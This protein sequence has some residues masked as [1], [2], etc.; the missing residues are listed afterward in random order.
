MTQFFWNKKNIRLKPE[1][2]LVIGFASLILVGSLLLSLPAATQSGESTSYLD[3]LFTSTSAVCVTGLVVYDTGTH[4]SMF[5]QTLIALLIQ[6]GGLGFMTFGILFAV[7]LGRKIGLRSRLVLQESLREFSLHGVV[8]LAARILLVTLVVELLATSLLATKFVPTL[9]LWRG[10]WF[11]FFHSVSAFNNAGFDIFGSINGQF[12][13]LT[14]YVTE[15]LVVL[16]LA[17]LFIM[18]GIG[19]TVFMDAVQKRKFKDLALHSKLVLWTTGIL[20]MVATLVIFSLERTNLQTIGNMSFGTGLMN[21]F[22]QAVTPRTAGFNTL[23]IAS[24]TMASQMFIILLMYVGA[25]PGS[26]GGGIKTSTFAVM[27]AG[28]TTLMGQKRDVVLFNRK[29]PSHQINKVFFILVLSLGVILLNTFLLTITETGAFIDILFEV[30]SAYGTVG[31]SMG[32]T[33]QLTPFGRFII[34]LTMFIGRLGAP[35]VAFALARGQ[36]KIEIGYPEER[37]I[38][39]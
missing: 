29:I 13:S 27:I 7:L 33:T 22:F 25:S 8:Q 19:F 24:M 15:P 1:Q 26:T 36:K 3:A 35:T 38:L 21:A 16:T 39:G 20:I 5:G 2:V 18:G 31:L 11:S 37:V 10:L 17:F 4:W 30:V 23:H 12:S 32:M 14:T 34:I 6:I 28:A 9:G